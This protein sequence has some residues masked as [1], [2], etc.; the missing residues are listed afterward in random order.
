M[1]ITMRVCDICK[2][3]QPDARIKYKYR[4][5]KPAWYSWN[6]KD[7]VKIE[8]C[9]DCLDKIIEAN[10]KSKIKKMTKEEIE[11][12]LKLLD[13]IKTSSSN[14]EEE[15]V[16]YGTEKYIN[17]I[18]DCLPPGVSTKAL[19]ASYFPEEKDNLLYV[20]PVEEM[21]PL[22]FIFEEEGKKI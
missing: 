10:T 16:V 11:E 5:K 7:W 9:Q 12:I 17:Q 18:K 13:E 4:A 8:L 3:N 19:P 2:H 20:I 6:K 1:K 22:K 14:T 15:F 21:V